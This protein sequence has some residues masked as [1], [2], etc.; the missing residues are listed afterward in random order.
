MSITKAELLKLPVRK[1]L[2]TVHEMNPRDL[3]KL[4]CKGEKFDDALIVELVKN[5]RANRAYTNKLKAGKR[6]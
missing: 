6:V 5:I 4:V 2:K 1:R 3:S